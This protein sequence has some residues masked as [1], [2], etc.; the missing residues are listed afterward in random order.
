MPDGVPKTLEEV[1]KDKAQLIYELNKVRE[2][3]DQAY[4]I[5]TRCKRGKPSCLARPDL[6]K[7]QSDIM[8]L[9]GRK[10][11]QRPHSKVKRI[12]PRSKH[13]EL[14]LKMRDQGKTI[15]KEVLDDHGL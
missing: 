8:E 13:L 3:I 10:I 11:W 7:R 6:Y 4:W 15:P 12:I 1:A 14:V 2:E 9:L 5:F